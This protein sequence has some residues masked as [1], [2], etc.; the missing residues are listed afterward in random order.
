MIAV[1]I[2][3]VVPAAVFAL[4]HG[5]IF[6]RLRTMLVFLG[7]CLVVGNIF[8]NLGVL[9]GFPYGSYYFTDV[10]GPKLFVVPIFLGLA[11]VGM[12]YLSWTLARL[13]L[14]K[15]E[16]PLACSQ[17]L[18]VPPLAGVI[19]VAWD[20]CMDPVW[21][22]LL[23]PWIWRRG[24]A[25]FGV[26]V[27]NFFGWYLD[28][29]VIYQLFAL[30]LRGRQPAPGPTPASYWRLAVLFYAVSAAGNLL[31]MIPRAGFEVVSDA[32]G[33]V[34]RVSDITRATALS[35][36]FTM[37]AFAMAAWLRLDAQSTKEDRLSGTPLPEIA[38]Q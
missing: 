16:S 4:I 11:Y 9:T 3:H 23:H 25:Y 29:F 24:G 19:M 14:G 30:Y 27:S 18:T 10:T 22:T 38:S 32:A 8:E 1:V 15:S 6:Y 21:S 31:L 36:I 12:A 37:G 5:S 2:L 26:P 35:S 7:I 13:I 28:V 17:V 34:W 20:F 33:T